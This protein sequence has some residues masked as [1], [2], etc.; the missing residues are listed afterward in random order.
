MERKVIWKRVLSL[1]DVLRERQR[2]RE[3][4]FQRHYAWDSGDDGQLTRLGEDIEEK[5]NDF[6]SGGIA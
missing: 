5:A 3:P 4:V 6:L 1:D 2:R